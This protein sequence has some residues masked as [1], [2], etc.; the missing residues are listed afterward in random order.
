LSS[1]ARPG[2]SIA[3]PQRPFRPAA[4]LPAEPHDHAYLTGASPVPASGQTTSDRAAATPVMT[5]ALTLI[6]HKIVGIAAR[7][8][9][10][11]GQP[12]RG[13]SRSPMPCEAWGKARALRNRCLVT[14]T[15]GG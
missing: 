5:M 2:T 13:H 14:P 3:V 12:V 4:Q 15:D 11:T 6:S 1:A 8:G 10:V 7:S 9:F